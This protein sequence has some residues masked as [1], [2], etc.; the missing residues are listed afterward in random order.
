MIHRKRKKKLF[1]RLIK[2]FSLVI[3][4]LLTLILIGS[5]IFFL[6]RNSIAEE[7]LL[8]LNKNQ[9]G[10]IGFS[11][12]SLSPFVHFPAASVRL[13]GFSYI[14]TKR[15]DSVFNID[16]LAVLQN[17]YAA[18]NIT[19][20][21]KG[22]IN[23]SEIT[24]D[25]G[26]I[27]LIKYPDSSINLLN[28][29]SSI[30]IGQ[31]NRETGDKENISDTSNKL[32]QS[33]TLKLSDELDISLEKI[34]LKEITV[35]FRDLIKIEKSIIE[36][37]KLNAS[38]HYQSDFIQ[39]RLKA[40]LNLL[41]LSLLEKFTIT[42]KNLH[43]ETDILFNRNNKKIEIKPSLLTFEEAN[44][45]LSGS[46]DLANN[47]DFDLVIDGSDSDFSFFQLWLS[48][49]G[50]E[51]LQSGDIYF[52]GTVKG[53]AN[54]YMPQMD[55]VFGLNDVNLYLPDVKASVSGLQL[56]GFFNSGTK[57]DFS[58]AKLQIKKLKGLLPGGHINAHFLLENF[59]EPRFDIL[60]D[61]KTDLRGFKNVLKIQ[62][63]DSLEGEVVIYD[64]LK[65]YFDVETNEIV[66]EESESTII[67]DSLSIL[68]PDVIRVKCL[69][70]EVT[71]NLDTLEIVDLICITEDSDFL[72]NGSIVNLLYLILDKEKEIVA[73]LNI[74]S[75]IFD[76]PQFFAFDPNVGHSFPYR[77]TDLDMDVI[78]ITS[79]TKLLEFN[80]N[81]E[82]QFEIRQMNATIEDLFP[83]ITIYKGDILLAKKEERIYMDFQNFDLDVEGSFRN[84]KVEYISP[85]IGPDIVIVEVSV[86]D[87]NPG[88]LLLDEVDTIPQWANGSL[89]GFVKTELEIGLD[90][91]DF[92]TF[93]IETDELSYYTE[94]DTFEINNLTIKASRID[95]SLEEIFN[96]LATLSFNA[97]IDASRFYSNHFEVED[98]SYEVDAREGTYSVIPEKIQFFGEEGKGMYIVSPFIEVP[99]YKL[100]YSVNQFRIDD[101]LKNMLTDTILTGNMDLDI[102]V[103][104]SGNDQEALFSNLNGYINISGENLT[105]YGI[106]LDKVI[107]KYNRSQKFNLVDIGAVVISPYA[108]ILTK[109]SDFAR[110]ALGNIGETTT[111]TNFISTW[112]M[113]EGKIIL[114][115]VAFSTEKNLIA[116]KGS[117]DLATD[118]L[119]VTIAVLDKNRCSVLSQTLFGTM[120]NPQ[121]SEIK[122]VGTVLAPITNLIN[123]ALG[124][125]CE[126]FYDG[127]LEHPLK[128]KKK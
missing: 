68:I 116:G 21:I 121:Q 87:L 71:R 23:I 70:G 16:T 84:A 92:E 35:E 10:E 38:F 37:N 57:N 60:W 120:E 43:I 65:G 123:G 74:K 111:I 67:F 41:E 119:D 107:E 110:L 125:D 103:T 56:E 6:Y 14:E 11:E 78:A 66:E 73:N 77:I 36:L 80:Y 20:L 105:L 83:P 22:K 25:I 63:I 99:N 27:Y 89:N 24:L 112:D 115:D 3:I 32:I 117:I 48:D 1:F 8:S 90:T 101:F 49:T 97:S 40:H 28:A 54:N 34:A 88:K 5:G 44:F 104:L 39:S 2:I 13:H 127:K 100:I 58:G 79:T 61:L 59:V 128:G 52:R 55:F 31:S 85:P 118:S 33:D 29:F 98:I 7:L 64:K 113:V 30:N 108:L 86:S 15:R 72:I 9:N 47:V 50:L 26:K 106:D 19:D 95:Y 53:P 46:V 69:D 122:I 102:D 17:V 12:I 76:L 62:S 51:N 124:K 82:I 45:E 96:P 93:N 114:K 81:P 126:V 94:T 109:G 42:D 18:I 75:E 4:G 91:L